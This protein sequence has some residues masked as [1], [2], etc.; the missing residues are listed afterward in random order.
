MKKTIQLDQAGKSLLE[1]TRKLI[2]KIEK[3]IPM[4]RKSITGVPNAEMANEI[5]YHFASVPLL[6]RMSML[7]VCMLFKLYLESSSTTEQNLLLRLISGQLYEF[8]EDVPGLFGKKFRHILSQ[9]SDL[10]ELMKSFNQDV[11]K[12]FHI[13]K[14]RHADFL[15]LIRHN[16][17]HHKDVDA[18]WQYYLINEIDF[19]WAIKAY[20][21]F[22]Q[23][24]VVN[25]SDFE[26]KLI[27]I[28]IKAEGK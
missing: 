1:T 18:L 14:Q 21:D 23:W 7:D 17:A 15:K 11:I 26:L 5:S 4:L 19:N 8:S 28:A 2:E 25:F 27:E 24:Y 22:V 20:I 3:E 10:D 13:L 12:E 6:L 16:V 9:F